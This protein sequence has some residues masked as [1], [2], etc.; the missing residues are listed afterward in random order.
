MEEPTVPAAPPDAPPGLL[1][2]PL[3][4]LSLVLLVDPALSE[5]CGGAGGPP[6]PPA[7]AGLAADRPG[8]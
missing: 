8:R 3:A 1:D 6:D 4:L 2:L 5:L 7:C